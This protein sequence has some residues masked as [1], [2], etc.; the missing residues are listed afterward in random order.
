VKTV[1]KKTGMTG[2]RPIDRQRAVVVHTVCVPLLTSTKLRFSHSVK[3][4]NH[5][6][7]N[8]RRIG[9][10]L[11][12]QLMCLKKSK[13]QSLTGANKLSIFN[14]KTRYFQARKYHVRITSRVEINTYKL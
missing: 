1:I 5:R 3:K 13:A 2:S 4:I 11:S 6:H 7:T 12:L 14:G 9:I 8:A 10:S